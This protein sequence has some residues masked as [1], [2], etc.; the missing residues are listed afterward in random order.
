MRTTPWRAPRARG[1]V[2]AAAGSHAV[3]EDSLQRARSD[4]APSVRRRRRRRRRRDG[5]VGEPRARVQAARRARPAARRC[6][7]D[8]RRA[9]RRGS[10]SRAHDRAARTA[11]SGAATV[12]LCA[13]DRPSAVALADRVGRRLPRLSRLRRR[14]RAGGAADARRHLSPPR[15]G[16]AAGRIA[17]RS[18]ADGRQRRGLGAE[19]GER[20]ACAA[21]RCWCSAATALHKHVEPQEIERRAAR[22]ARRSRAAAAGSSSSRARAAAATMRRCSSCGACPPG[23]SR[24][25]RVGLAL[26]AALAV[27]LIVAT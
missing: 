15:R 3:N 26:V 4:V 18:G 16:A 21:A 9:A 11:A 12:A 20:R 25:A 27:A 1:G 5:V 8:S 6:G 10:R 23:A 17:R 24:V 2:R 7:L 13:G 19:C 22:D 14:R